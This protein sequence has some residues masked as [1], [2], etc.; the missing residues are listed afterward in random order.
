MN[1]CNYSLVV[2]IAIS[3]Y[4]DGI[5]TGNLLFLAFNMIV[6]IS[7][8]FLCNIKDKWFTPLIRK[9]VYVLEGG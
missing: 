4:V 6:F 2:W 3:F 9:P 1:R 7:F 8:C 5:P